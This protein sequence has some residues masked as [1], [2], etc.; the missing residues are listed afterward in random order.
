MRIFFAF[1]VYEG[2]MQSRFRLHPSL[3]NFE[4]KEN[5][6]KL[7]KFGNACELVH[8]ITSYVYGVLS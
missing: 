2:A 3:I 5:F 1:K 6:G 7:W 8:P 4:G